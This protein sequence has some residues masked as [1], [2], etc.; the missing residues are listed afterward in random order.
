M[1][2]SGTPTMTA[3]N[4]SGYCVS[5]LPASRPPL[6]R[7]SIPRCSGVVIPR[8]TRSRATAVKSS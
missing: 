2:S 8:A 1:S 4:S 7:P 5:M 6:E 3:P